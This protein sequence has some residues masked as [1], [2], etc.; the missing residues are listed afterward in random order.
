MLV[1]FGIPE[2]AIVTKVRLVNIDFC[3]SWLVYRWQWQ[4]MASEHDSDLT[5]GQ[6]ALVVIVKD[7]TDDLVA[8]LRNWR[9]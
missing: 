7:T 4:V 8:G 5:V 3:S 9:R 6:E 1:H 2:K